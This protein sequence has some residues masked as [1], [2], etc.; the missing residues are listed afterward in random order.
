M[1]VILVI[2][3][4]HKDTLPAGVYEVLG[5]ARAVAESIGARVKLYVLGGGEVPD[6]GGLY[7]CGAHSAVFV[8]GSGPAGYSTDAYAGIA[9]GIIRKENPLAVLACSTFFSRDYL[10]LAAAQCGSDVITD[11]LDVTLSGTGKM[12]AIKPGPGDGTATVT[13]C[14]EGAVQ[15]ALFRPGVLDTPVQTPGATDSFVCSP[16]EDFWQPCA[17]RVVLSEILYGSGAAGLEQADLIVA[18]G[19]GMKTKENFRLLGLLAEKLGG[20]L[21]CTRPCVDLGWAPPTRQIG[22]TGVS[23]R[24]VVY[25]AFGISGAIQHVTGLTKARHIFAVNTDPAAYI[26]NICSGGAVADAAG[27]ARQMLAA[28]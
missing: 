18:G 4:M 10:P 23:V 21:A 7:T 20:Q 8:Q 2:A 13:Y 26:F 11:C 28:E 6:A 22:Q 14:R 27:V 19:R 17:P 24:P 15:M 25:L 16:V 1:A 9:A 5:K 3:E 12:Q